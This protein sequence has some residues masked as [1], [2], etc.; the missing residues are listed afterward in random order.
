MAP[1]GSVV[2]IRYHNLIA[3]AKLAK[4]AISVSYSPKHD[5]LMDDLGLGEFCVPARW[6]DADLLIDRFRELEGRSAELTLTLAER[7]NGKTERLA[8][9]FALLSDILLPEFETAAAEAAVP[10]GA[11]SDSA[12][13]LAG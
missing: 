1:V 3:A 10:P 4:P 6:L 2:G 7:V 8:E 13:S 5:V 12:R 11:A 9:Q